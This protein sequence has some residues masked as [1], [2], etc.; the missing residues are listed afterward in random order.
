MVSNEIEDKS[1][2]Q[3]SVG[4]SALRSGRCRIASSG[5]GAPASSTTCRTFDEV[6]EISE[7]RH[8][9]CERAT[10]DR[11]VRDVKRERMSQEKMSD[12]LT[13]Q[14]SGVKDLLYES[15]NKIRHL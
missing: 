8:E 10:N 11:H 13:E 6:G 3:T 1:T 12:C 5:A 9:P 2:A 4:R 7:E 15:W 14:K